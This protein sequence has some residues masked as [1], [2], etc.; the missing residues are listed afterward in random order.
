MHWAWWTRRR[1]FMFI[2]FNLHRLLLWWGILKDTVR[3]VP[4]FWHVSRRKT[5]HCCWDLRERRHLWKCLIIHV[6]PVSSLHHYKWLEQWMLLWNHFLVCLISTIKAFHPPFC[7]VFVL[8]LLLYLLRVAFSDMLSCVNT[9]PINPHY[10]IFWND[11]E[12]SCR[13]YLKT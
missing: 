5:F 9:D 10:L 11:F 1:A 13:G 6:A 3:N 2:W 4:C 7:L 12:T 8:C